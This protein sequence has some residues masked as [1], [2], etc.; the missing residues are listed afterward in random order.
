MITFRFSGRQPAP[1]SC[2]IGQ[3]TDRDTQTLRFFLPQI[4]DR[5]SAQLMLL[6]PDGTPEIL[7]I[8]D[9]LAVVPSTLTEQPGRI[10]A[11]VEI[12]GE[13]TLTWNSELF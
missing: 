4:S 1:R 5:Q 2:S 13:D 10:R 3:E 11:W 6:L 12:L 7:Q 8:R 9:G